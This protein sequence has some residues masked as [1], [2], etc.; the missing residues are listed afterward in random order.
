[1]I[2]KIKKIQKGILAVNS[3]ITLEKYSLIFGYNG[4]GKTTLAKSFYNIEENGIIENQEYKFE[5]VDSNLPY[6]RV[7]YG[8]DYIENNI[9]A[10]KLNP[11]RFAIG[12]DLADKKAE[13]DRLTE[14]LEKVDTKVNE[15][16]NK[17]RQLI[18][19]NNNLKTSNAKIIKESL[20][21]PAYIRNT[22]EKDILTNSQVISEILNYT[23]EEKEK[24][25][26]ANRIV[27][28]NKQNTQSI[29]PIKEIS[30]FLPVKEQQ[31]LTT[32]LN[33]KF[34]QPEDFSALFIRIKAEYEKDGNFEFQEFIQKGLRFK[35]HQD[36][37]I[38]PFCFQ[39]LGELFNNFSDYFNNQVTSHIIELDKLKSSV[40]SI[41]HNINSFLIS[42]PE[43]HLFFHD[44]HSDIEKIRLA[45]KI[46]ATEQ[47]KQLD[48]LNNLIEQKIKNPYLQ[49]IFTIVDS[50][51]NLEEFRNTINQFNS[52]IERHNLRVNSFEKEREKARIWLVSYYIAPIV[53]V[54]NSNTA[55]SR[56]YTLAIDK[57]NNAIISLKDQLL[58]VEK[59][60]IDYKAPIYEYNQ[61]LRRILGRADITI[62]YLEDKNSYILKRHDKTVEW[63]SFSEGE[64]TVLAITHFILSLKDEKNNRKIQDC[65]VVIDD[66]ICSLDTNSIFAI[67]AFLK[68]ELKD[69]KQLIILT[70]HFY[71]L[72]ITQ[73]WFK[74]ADG[75][76]TFLFIERERNISN[77]IKLPDYLKNYESEYQYLFDKLQKLKSSTLCYEDCISLPNDCRKLLESVSVFLFPFFE[78]KHD[79]R[80]IA[81]RKLISNT[82]TGNKEEL[83]LCLDYVYRNSNTES[84]LQLFDDS[85][86][87]HNNPEEAKK[88]IDAIITVIE[89]L[90]PHH[91]ANYNIITGNN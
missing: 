60:L 88:L 68:R 44:E 31:R 65:I 27:F 51:K 87:F 54:L 62:D 91:L 14:V 58:V 25:E 39:N 33:Q 67:Y 77:I 42:F 1:M 13:R 70:H 85:L 9:V 63:K 84:H 2:K 30:L 81:I 41:K 59:D 64:K 21:I 28:N 90:L 78:R 11:I 71:F 89:E 4:S 10:D 40:V 7:F 66:P 15:L 8:E 16:L 20:G 6:L 38:C 86:Y 17:S 83:E 56:K 82:Y 5:T 48:E 61:N 3:D 43:L 74:Y 72:K 24:K 79:E 76:K 45:C 36:E 23:E 55:R 29:T 80:I 46:Y 47:I 52:K 50:G 57:I 12:T 69:T 49:K 73:N 53:S 75:S 35:H 34:S 22:L 26:K 32:L 37:K 19:E 18:N